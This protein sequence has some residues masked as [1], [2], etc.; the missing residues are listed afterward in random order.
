[1][2]GRSRTGKSLE[3]GGNVGGL[4]GPDPLE[5]LQ[6][7]PQ[8]DLGLRGVADGHGASAQAGQCVSLVP[9]GGD[10]AGQF[11]GPLVAHLSL[12]GFTADPVQRPSLVERLGLTTPAAQVAVDAQGLL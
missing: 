10:G 6:C 7:L 1:L 5:D 2:R 9:G 11:Q 4:A 3:F 12:R 8:Q